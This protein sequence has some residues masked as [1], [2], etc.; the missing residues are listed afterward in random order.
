[1]LALLNPESFV[2]SSG[3]LAIFVLSVLQSCCVPTSSELTLGYAGVLAGQGTLSLPGVILAGTAG[4]VVGAYI[5]WIIGRTGGRAFVDRYGRYILVTHHDLD[6]AEAWYDRHDRWG[7]FGSRLLPVIRNFVALPAG[8]AE[9]PLVRFGILTAAGSLIWDGA[10]ALIG[11]GAS[12]T[13][14]SIEHGFNYAGY[15]LGFLVVVAIVALIAHRYRS[16]QAATGGGAVPDGRGAHVR[17]RE[18]PRTE[19]PG[20][21]GGLPRT[22]RPDRTGG[23]PRA[24]RPGRA[25]RPDRAERPGRREPP[26]E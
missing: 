3:Y 4:E 7:V 17:R 26:L 8:A 16:Y 18:P 20:R 9:V 1:V 12:G 25:E 14:T 21:T 24:E 22:E 2:K 19:R 10:W 6:R 15:L 11:Y 13:W 5:A 23:L